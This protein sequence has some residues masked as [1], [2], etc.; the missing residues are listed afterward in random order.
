MKKTIA[1]SLFAL[2]ASFATAH[3]AD[4]QRWA[5]RLFRFDFNCTFGNQMTASEQ[6][7]GREFEAVARVFANVR[8]DH[9]SHNVENM[10]DNAVQTEGLRNLLAVARN[11][12][13]FYADGALL[14]SG[15]REVVIAAANGQ[16]LAIVIPRKDHDAPA[17]EWMLYPA[18]LILG[19][20]KIPGACEVR[21]RPVEKGHEYDDENQQTAVPAPLN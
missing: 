8:V 15:K 4:D 21:A 18:A 13:L 19:E 2:L 5:E 9:E 11:G 14:N 10:F 17:A 20:H 16:R 12:N 6:Q 1:F 7:R 3:A